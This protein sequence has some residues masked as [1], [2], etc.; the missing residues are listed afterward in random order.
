MSSA[1]TSPS[2]TVIGGAP[3]ELVVLRALGG[4]RMT[5]RITQ[6]GSDLI[7]EPQT[8]PMLFMHA[9]TEK[10]ADVL[11]LG[12]ALARI[13]S[14]EI[15]VRGAIIGTANPQKMRRLLN[16][17]VNA[18]AT[19]AEVAR[20]VLLLDLD[21]L[22]IPPGFDPQLQSQD[23]IEMLIAEHLPTEFHR[24]S[25]WWQYTGGMGIKPGMRLRLGFVLSRPLGRDDLR[26][27]LA[28]V[29]LDLSVF[30]ASQPILV[31]HPALGPGVTDPVPTRSGLIT[32]ANHRVEP[33]SEAVLATMAT[34][35]KTRAPAQ[36]R[37][38][39]GR[40]PTGGST[41]GGFASHLASIGDAPGQRGLYGPLTSAVGARMLAHGPSSDPAP[42]EKALRDAV[43]AANFD[44]AK[45]PAPYIQSKLDDIPNII[46][47]IARLEAQRLSAI[48]AQQPKRVAAPRPLPAATADEVVRL[49]AAEVERFIRAMPWLLKMR[50]A[51][52][53]RAA[54]SNGTL[55]Y[56]LEAAVWRR[57]A[58]IS[59]S[60]GVG[61]S[62]AVIREI[63]GL[64]TDS[65]DLRITYV[66]PEHNLAADIARRFDQLAGSSYRE[67]MAGTDTARSRRCC[68]QD[69]PP[70]RRSR[71]G[72]A[73]RRRSRQPLR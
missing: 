15:V 12:L 60:P 61:K 47:G 46:E 36:P 45:H 29:P 6:A 9:R 7:V 59:V 57:R 48:R 50:S 5:K 26:A 42:L 40:A 10:A 43:A 64:T 44:A 23:S 17:R 35:R 52:W 14:D 65:P 22:P 38:S 51:D 56:G 18:P 16:A 8:N 68:R 66:V 53:S 2:S 4:A 34:M 24:V 21:S 73:R 69:V 41:G 71:V 55:P 30:T 25:C 67:R 72:S 58:G 3:D 19:I 49:V 39:G 70:S 62:E 11:R 20:R 37:A 54:M 63:V 1:A 33:P 28:A 31:A 32:G 27:W 13:G